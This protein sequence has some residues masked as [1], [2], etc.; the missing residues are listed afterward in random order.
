[1]VADNTTGGTQKT[2]L[3]I[4]LFMLFLYLF[5]L[6]IQ[7][8]GHGFEALGGDAAKNF[9]R[10]AE[11]PFVG[12]F[13]RILATSLFQSSSTT[14]SLVVGLVAAEAL[15]LNQAIPMVMGAN[16]GTTVTNIIVS[17]GHIGR[18]DEFRRAFAAALMHDSFN[19]LSVIVIF[20]LWFFTH[21]LDRTAEF[22]TAIFSGAKG[23]SFSSPLITMTHSPANA[24]G[25][26]LGEIGWVILIFSLIL[27]FVSLRYMVF[28]MKVL[29]MTRAEVIFER[30][31]FR[32]AFRGFFFG[33]ILTALVQSSSV[34]TSL[35]VPLAG[36]GMITLE[37]LFP[38]TMGANIGTTITAM[39]AALATGSAAG[40]S[41]AF[42]HLM[43][44]IS[45]ITIFWWIKFVPIRIAK[46]IAEVSAKNRIFAII[47]VVMMFF[48][49]PLLLIYLME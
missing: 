42:S 23:M 22:L 35:M 19:I 32:T 45:G 26:L 12:L 4:F 43:F 48:L 34:T 25:E 21:Y 8:L 37:R 30:T 6:S 27:L 5:L 18:R 41:V 10:P 24:I 14:T 2:F 38:Y 47:Y 44:N 46:F 29:I 13:I 15:T 11:N 33:M 1:M 9:L 7:L 39:L 20:P 40:V 49:I 31:V 36:A 16:I 17:L 3:N 28:Y